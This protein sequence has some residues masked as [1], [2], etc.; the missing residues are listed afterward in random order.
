MRGMAVKSVALLDRSSLS[1]D[2]PSKTGKRSPS[3]FT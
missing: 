3:H 1:P 2:V